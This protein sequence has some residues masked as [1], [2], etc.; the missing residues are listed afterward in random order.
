MINQVDSAIKQVEGQ[1]QNQQFTSAYQNARQLIPASE[2]AIEAARSGRA[3]NALSQVEETFIQFSNQGAAQYA[4]DEYRQAQEALQNLRNLMNQEAFAE[5]EAQAGQVISQIEDAEQVLEQE[6]VN[7]IA[8]AQEAINDAQQAE[9]QDY[10]ATMQANAVNL[11]NSAETAL[12]NNRYLEAIRQAEQAEQA[13][14]AA[15]SRSFQLRA[16]QNLRRANDFLALARQ[17]NQDRLNPLPYREARESVEA[18]D[19]L[20][21]QRQMEQAFEQSLRAVEDAEYSYNSTIK[22][23]EA[24]V[25]DALDA[26]AMNYTEADVQEA[27]RRLQEAEQAQQARNFAIANQQA[28]QAREIASRAEYETYRQRTTRLVEELDRIRAEMELYHAEDRAPALYQRAL[29][30]SAEAKIAH[31]EE[32]YEEAFRQADIAREAQS[33]FINGMDRELNAIV[34]E[35]GQTANWIG[36]NA[37]T[38]EGRS[39]KIDFL[40]DLAEL[41]KRIALRQWNEAYTQADLVVRK[42][43]KAAGRFE[44]Y[45]KTQMA[46]ALKERLQPYKNKNALRSVPEQQQLFDETM[47][48]LK[49]STPGQTFADVTERFEASMEISEQ[50][51]DLIVEQA[52][53]Q[54]EEISG[55]LQQAIE[56]GSRRFFPEKTRELTS[57]LQWLRNSIEGED[58]RE[59]AARLKKLETQAPELLAS[60]QVA[61][62]EEEYLTALNNNL[63][64][65]NTLVQDFDSI[66][67]MPKELFLASRRRN[68]K[69][70]GCDQYVSGDADG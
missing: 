2:Q 38:P 52:G 28:Q 66:L 1:L 17:A 64:A 6:A 41:E 4:P 32:D 8:D 21:R 10:V 12:R 5:V 44:K 58:Y 60:T 51:P 26:G 3:R 55:V 61:I 31:L 42:A 24:Q 50:L 69:W 70:T 29:A 18:T 14:R 11:R 45:S 9:A 43:D 20:L 23:A 33:A 30:A 13:A 22:I 35:V 46:Q 37:N 36:L 19:N 40:G 57:D 65:M 67:S 56:G 39:Y 34:E 16:E 63:E 7:R 25:R 59:I 48:S 68:T 49:S 53:Q 54:T 62:E 15:R 47:K 27:L